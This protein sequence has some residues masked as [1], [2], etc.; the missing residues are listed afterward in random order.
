MEAVEKVGLFAPNLAILDLGMPIMN[1]FQAACEISKANPQL[2]YFSSVCR[3]FPVNSLRQLAVLASG[4]R[5]PR[6]VAVATKLCRL[7]KL[8]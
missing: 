8:W 4:E 3:K 1:G 6:V 5:L 2:R 7:L